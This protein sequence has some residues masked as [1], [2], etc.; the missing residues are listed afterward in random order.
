MISI[1]FKE[2]NHLIIRINALT[3][4]YSAFHFRLG[5]LINLM[6]QVR[7]VNPRM[8]GIE[9]C[10]NLSQDVYVMFQILC[11]EMEF[12]QFKHQFFLLF[13]LKTLD[14]GIL[15]GSQTLLRVIAQITKP[16]IVFPIALPVFFP[17]SSNKLLKKPI[18]FL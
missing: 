11:I 18:F 12:H 1:Y 4:S 17:A 7:S 15:L 14:V 6:L 13:H 2:C 10:R 9:D 16:Y 8:K 3:H 5:H